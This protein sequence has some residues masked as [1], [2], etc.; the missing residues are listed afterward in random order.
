MNKFN[1]RAVIFGFVL[2]VSGAYVLY[3]SYTALDAYNSYV[4]QSQVVQNV[5]QT[6]GELNGNMTERQR[7]FRGYIIT[8]DKTFVD[9]FY[10]ATEDGARQIE[11]LKRI[12]D[13]EPDQAENLKTLESQF[14][15]ITNLAEAQIPNIE[16]NNT[17]QLKE[18]MLSKT[19]Q[20][21]LMNYRETI[22]RIREKEQVLINSKLSD[23]NAQ[24]SRAVWGLIYLFLLQCFTVVFLT[25]SIIHQNNTLSKAIDNSKSV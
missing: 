25:V 2:L 15:N 22:S 4:A 20:I 12:L 23:A 11:D 19:G 24:Y 13:S 14:V 16:Q 6:L 5:L 17:E 8:A 21:T 7:N 9:D 18:F 10:E 1:L 3:N